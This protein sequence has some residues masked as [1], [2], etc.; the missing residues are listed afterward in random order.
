M[1]IKIHKGDVAV[2]VCMNNIIFK[3]EAHLDFF[4][5]YLPV[6]RKQDCYHAALVYCLGMNGDTRRNINQIYDFKI[7][8]VKTECLHEGWQTSGSLNVVRMAFNLYC[9]ST[10][11]MYDYEELTDQLSECSKY[12]VEDLFSCGYAPYFWQAIKIRYP[13]YCGSV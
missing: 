11:S 8:N 12:T 2:N 5:Q 9:N 13:E 4:R 10:P 3:S 7:G 1:F 6:C